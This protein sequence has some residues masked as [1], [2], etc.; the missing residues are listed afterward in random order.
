MRWERTAE[1][2]RDS[3]LLLPGLAPGCRQCL[4]LSL[5]EEQEGGIDIVSDVVK[6]QDEDPATPGCRRE[7]RVRWC[8]SDFQLLGARDVL[9]GKKGNNEFETGYDP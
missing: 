4:L 9:E 5:F 6:V 1:L 7:V 8:V 3:S 2:D